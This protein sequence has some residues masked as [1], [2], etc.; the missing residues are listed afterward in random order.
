LHVYHNCHATCF[1]AREIIIGVSAELSMKLGVIVQTDAGYRASKKHQTNRNKLVVL[2]L[3]YIAD[4]DGV[5]LC[6]DELSTPQHQRLPVV[7]MSVAAMP[8]L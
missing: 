7:H 3:Y 5:P 8:L 4:D 1:D 2:H 6:F